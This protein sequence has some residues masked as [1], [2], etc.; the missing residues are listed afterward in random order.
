MRLR[1]D[2]RGQ[3]RGPKKIYDFLGITL[4]AILLTVIVLSLSFSSV[5]AELIERVIA[6]VDDIAITLSEFELTYQNTQKVKP[7]ISKGEV[8]NTMINRVLLLRDAKKL[9]ISAP[10]DDAI[11]NEY[12]DFKIRAFIVVPEKEIEEFYKGHKEEFKGLKLKD[13][14]ESIETLLKEK[15]VN[16][17]L[18]RHIEKLKEGSYIK[19][20]EPSFDLGP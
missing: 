6:F 18:K 11:I 4:R 8:L 14:R 10:T 3:N 17:R 7:N 20:N 16:E 15:E 13:V 1:K 12:I 19:V 9:R 2:Q 5:S